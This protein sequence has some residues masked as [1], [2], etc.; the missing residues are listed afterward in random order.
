M[1]VFGEA[2]TGFH[3]EQIEGDPFDSGSGPSSEEEP[4]EDPD[5]SPER[6]ESLFRP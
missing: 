1:E 6:E 2:N 5:S 4:N 3:P